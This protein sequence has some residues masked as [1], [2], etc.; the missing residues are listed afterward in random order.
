MLAGTAASTNAVYAARQHM[1]VDYCATNNEQALPASEEC[2]LKYIAG[3]H[4]AGRKSSTCSGHL[5]AI[6]HL[7]LINGLTDPL[8]GRDRLTLVKR[9]MSVNSS[10]EPLRAAITSAHLLEFLEFLDLSLFSDM[11]FFAMCSL[12][13][14]G[15]FRI[16]E[17]TSSTSS[18]VPDCSLTPSDVS[19]SEDSIQV[20]LKT[21]KTDRTRSGVRVHIG[22]S[23][24][25]VCALKALDIYLK[26]R[27]A[28][29]PHLAPES[30][31]LFVNESGLPMSKS[32]FSKRLASLAAKV[33]IEGKVSP[34]SLRIGA[35]TVAWTEGFS[36]SQIQ[37]LGRWKSNAFLRYIRVSPASISRLSA[38]LGASTVQLL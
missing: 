16:S 7:H 34:H 25:P 32:V 27:T 18:F 19:W 8:L 10:P 24:S 6:R 17:M 9:G 13:F 20:F 35:A 33:G 15:F 28:S 29:F 11:A 2:L 21:S 12:G 31:P 36:D 3:L 1:F 5:S 26:A 38:S 37:A 30:S 23:S 14:Y 22:R 4:S